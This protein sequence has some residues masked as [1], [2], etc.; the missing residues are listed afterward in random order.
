[1][2]K[3]IQ[4]QTADKACASIRRIKEDGAK[5]YDLADCLR[6][7]VHSLQQ[8]LQYLA[9][10]AQTNDLQKLQSRCERIQELINMIEPGAFTLQ[11]DG[12]METL[13]RKLNP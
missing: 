13:W 12:T 1:M 11:V 5:V 7:K 4:P 9:V 6:S 8:E 3:A 2:S 10:T